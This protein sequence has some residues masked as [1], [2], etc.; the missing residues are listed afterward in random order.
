MKLSLAR[1]LD[2]LILRMGSK[3][4]ADA[5]T[6]LLYLFAKYKLSDPHP[7]EFLPN[8]LG[9]YKNFGVQIIQKSLF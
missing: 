4:V 5:E 8:K 9:K 7:Q 2:D 1:R 3:E 6:K